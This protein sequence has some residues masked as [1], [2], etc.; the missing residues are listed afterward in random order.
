VRQLGEAIEDRPGIH[1]PRAIEGRPRLARSAGPSSPS[2]FT[3]IGLGSISTLAAN[4]VDVIKVQDSRPKRFP[5]L[6][7]RRQM[8]SVA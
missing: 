5:V 3:W 1:T 2:E 4:A 6:H 8:L 7:L